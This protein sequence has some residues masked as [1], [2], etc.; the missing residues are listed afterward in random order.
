[1]PSSLSR[2]YSPPS[3]GS[4]NRVNPSIGSPSLP[5]LGNSTMNWLN[6]NAGPYVP[7]AAGAGALATLLGSSSG[8][9]SQTFSGILSGAGTGA[10]IGSFI[11]GIGTAIGAGVG[12]LVGGISGAF[13]ET[14]QEQNQRRLGDFL[15]DLSVTKQKTLS[16][17]IRTLS[18]YS[19]NLTKRFRSNAARNAIA[20]GRTNDTQAFETPVAERAAAAGVGAVNRFTSDVNRQFDTAEI[21]ARSRY[22]FETPLQPNATDYFNAAAPEAID[23]ASRQ[24]Q[25]GILKDYFGQNQGGGLSDL[26]KYFGGK[27]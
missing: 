26:M 4:L 22:T 15:K 13:S 25:F 1:M 14:P 23:F 19:G 3:A 21:N 8:R 10:S 2:Y 12:A 27:T 7:Y 17:G 20:M 16:E 6:S 11:P 24:Q 9:K 18:T 5:N